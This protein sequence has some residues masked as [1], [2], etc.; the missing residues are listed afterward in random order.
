MVRSLFSGSHSQFSLSPL[1]RS[2]DSTRSSLLGVLLVTLFLFAPLTVLGQTEGDATD[3]A[4][5]GAAVS[6]VEG[7]AAET[8]PVETDELGM[9]L[10]QMLQASWEI[11]IFLV[12]LSILVVTLALYYTFALTERRLAPAD[13]STQFRHLLTDGR[14]ADV[15]QICRVRGGLFCQV[16][17]AGVAE[18]RERP[19]ESASR[20]DLIGTAMEQ[21]GRREADLLMRKV[22]YLSEIATI[23]PMLGLL[24]TVIGMIQAFNFI[25]FDFGTVKPVMLAG[26]VS[27]ALV[28]T[29]AGLIV[30]IPAMALYYIFRGRLQTILGRV[31][32]SAV[33]MNDLIVRAVQAIAEKH[34]GRG[35]TRR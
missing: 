18:A 1:S 25:A 17:L 28:T 30:A 5:D 10:F 22:R 13:L 16:V 15:E 24:G 32:V 34:R 8:E 11:M 31:E 19:Q 14:L 20:P 4:V 2:G 21:A 29:A 35:E 23:S 7:E 9:T 12:A 26:A 33:A 27:K 6:D 3:G